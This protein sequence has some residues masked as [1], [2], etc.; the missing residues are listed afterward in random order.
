MYKKDIFIY[1]RSL[2]VLSAHTVQISYSLKIKLNASNKLK[3]GLPNE[4]E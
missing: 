1:K 3:L 2:S 4:K